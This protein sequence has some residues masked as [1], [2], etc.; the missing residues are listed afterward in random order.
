MLGRDELVLHLL[1]ALLRRR[2]NL[3]ETRAEILLT[4]LNARKAR[5]R[6]LT[7]VLDYLNVRA[8]LSEQRTD[9]AF[10]LLKQRAQHVLR[11]DLLILIP[12]GQFN[13][14]LDRFLSS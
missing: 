1:G 13:A 9:D 14:G 2:E 8:E 4:S 3:R 10:R 6:C 7:V 11:F 12:F 5:D